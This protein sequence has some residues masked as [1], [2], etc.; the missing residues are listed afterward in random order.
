MMEIFRGLA[1]T[2]VLSCYSWRRE[3][4]SFTPV[5]QHFNP[6]FVQCTVRPQQLCHYLS[7]KAP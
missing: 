6:P 2:A 4:E 5:A 1:K 7:K 3:A